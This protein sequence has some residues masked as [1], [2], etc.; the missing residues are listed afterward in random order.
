VSLGIPPQSF[1]VIFDSGSK[2]FW[3]PKKGCE[4]IGANVEEC[5]TG[6][7]LYDPDLSKTS[8]RTNET[9]SIRYGS[10]TVSGTFWQDYFS[11]KNSILL[12]MF[13]L[14]SV[15]ISNFYN[16]S[17]EMLQQMRILLY[18]RR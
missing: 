16:F 1:K 18:R 7:H 14:L 8:I 10:G 9:F 5:S 13:I 2:T 3:V 12:V 4:S 6:Q 11:V 17:L 15:K